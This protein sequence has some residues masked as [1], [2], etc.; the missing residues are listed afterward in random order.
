M[1]TIVDT[2]VLN[3]RNLLR[4]ELKCSHKKKAKYVL[5]NCIVGIL[6]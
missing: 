5:M 2:S 6:P 4:G 3:N 1:V